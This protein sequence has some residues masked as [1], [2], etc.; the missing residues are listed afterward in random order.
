MHNLY[1]AADLAEANLLQGLLANAGI[2]V[3]IFNYYAQGA[4]GEIPPDQ[5]RP[6]LWLEI[7]TDQDKALAIIND[8]E[9]NAAKYKD[10]VFCRVCHEANPATFELC[11]HCGRELD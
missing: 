5:I 9:R 8:Y 1:T 6:Q 2:Q 11:W 3:H 10:T 4:S 7:K